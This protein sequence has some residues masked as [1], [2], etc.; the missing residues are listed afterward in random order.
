MTIKKPYYTVLDHT[1]DLGI[2]VYGKS[3]KNLFENAGMALM[4]LMVKGKSLEKTSPKSISIS[5]E[6][7]CDLMVRWLGELLYLFEGENLLVSSINIGYISDTRLEASLE[8]IHLNPKAHEILSEIKAVTYHQIEVADK[9]DHW[10]A[11]V[12]LDL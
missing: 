7:L 2:Q 5:G 3:L 4:H 11:K 8:T 6:D 12:I 1:A 10:E 9:G